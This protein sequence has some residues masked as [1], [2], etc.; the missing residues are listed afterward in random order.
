MEYRMDKYY[1]NGSRLFRWGV[2]S[3]DTID[4]RK[5]R[6]GVAYFYGTLA[7]KYVQFGYKGEG[8][9]HTSQTRAGLIRDLEKKS[10]KGRNRK[11]T[12]E[13]FALLSLHDLARLDASGTV[14]LLVPEEFISVVTSRATDKEFS[15]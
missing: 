13:Y 3:L 14:T 11:R 6:R 4:N 8:L 7:Q 9:I 12:Y 10:G 1:I 2:G 5:R 15:L